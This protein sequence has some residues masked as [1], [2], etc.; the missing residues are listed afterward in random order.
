M[1]MV[2][3]RGEVYWVNLNPTQGA[4]VNKVRPCLIVSPN[5]ANRHLKT[6]LIAP[7]T[8]SVHDYPTRV[9]CIIQNKPGEIMLDQMRAV[10]KDRLGSKMTELSL[11]DLELVLI[12]LRDY[13]A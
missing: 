6:V 1:D 10:S 7:I 5:Q 12:V 8:S 13:F 3:L 11:D 9:P 4:E 2:V